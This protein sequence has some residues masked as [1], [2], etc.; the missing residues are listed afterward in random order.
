[1]NKEQL[2]KIVARNT[3]QTQTT[4]EFV[5]NETLSVIKSCVGNGEDLTLI[6][7]GTFTRRLNRERVGRN[8][9]N[10]KQIK[11]LKKTVPKFRPGQAFKDLF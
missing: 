4:V 1:M 5:I 10:G 11:I 7:F 8:P 3:N 6:G 2:I 9:K